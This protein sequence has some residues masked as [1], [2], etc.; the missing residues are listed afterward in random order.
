M[1][2]RLSS[3][4][5]FWPISGRQRAEILSAVRQTVPDDRRYPLVSM[6]RVSWS[7][8]LVI[9]GQGGGLCGEWIDLVLRR[10]G[11]RWVV[12]TYSSIDA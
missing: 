5:R 8:V 7:E 3:L 11:G 4:A 1:I 9:V 12:A 10:R 6:S 2:R